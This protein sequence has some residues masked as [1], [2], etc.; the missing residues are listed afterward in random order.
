M[1]VAEVTD[2]LVEAIARSASTWSCATSPTR[3][4]SAIPATSPPRCAPPKRWTRRSA[5]SP[6]RCAVHGVLVVTAD[7]GNPK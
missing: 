5:T 2:K 3:T 1:S 7:H 6:P 4:W